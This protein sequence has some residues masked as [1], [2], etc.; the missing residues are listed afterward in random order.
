MGNVK[1]G[2]KVP[3]NVK[4]ALLFD[5]ANGDN[6]WKEAIIKEVSA[7]M[8]QKT[9]EYLEGSY[10]NLK[11]KGFMFAPLRMIFDVKQDGRRKAR[12]VIG[13]HVLDSENMDTYSSVMKAISARLL[14]VIAKAN[15][16]TV[17]TGDIKNAYL[18][19]ECDIKVCTRVRPEFELAG[20]TLIKDGLMA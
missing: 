2:V 11:T 8:G 12:L 9:F 19:A 17:R 15:N 14:M 7:I 13:G 6:L 4:E 10:K 3:H 1:Y 20:Y 16:Y 18:Y 5:K